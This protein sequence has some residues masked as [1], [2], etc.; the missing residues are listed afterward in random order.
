MRT[1]F[2]LRFKKKFLFNK[3]LEQITKTQKKYRNLIKINAMKTI[4]QST[5]LFELEI[6]KAK[7]E[8]EG[9]QSFIKNEF[10]NNVVVMPINQDYFLL[11]NEADYE[12]ALTILNESEP[13]I[14]NN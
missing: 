12:R 10:V 4:A 1:I 2:Y 11:V 9:I 13:E 5:I 7:L 6:L 8:S 3:F 14:E